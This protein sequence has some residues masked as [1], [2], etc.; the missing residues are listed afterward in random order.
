MQIRVKLKKK[1]SY[2]VPFG[3]SKTV[4]SDTLFSSH[5]FHRLCIFVY[6]KWYCA[7]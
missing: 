1:N 6:I 4:K 5:S 3:F 2:S 7:L